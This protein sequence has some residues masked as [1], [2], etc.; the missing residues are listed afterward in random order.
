MSQCSAFFAKAYTCRCVS[1]WCEGNKK[2]GINS[3]V[4]SDVFN[5]TISRK[6]YCTI[7][8]CTLPKIN[9]KFVHGKYT[10]SKLIL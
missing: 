7:L 10:P 5:K 6:A 3:K 2:I 1:V 8:I 4:C 9:S